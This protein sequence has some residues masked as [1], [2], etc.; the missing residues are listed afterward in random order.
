MAR[1][2]YYSAG[3]HEAAS[4]F[5][6]QKFF[7]LNNQQRRQAK[8]NRLATPEPVQPVEGILREQSQ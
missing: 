2:V 4:K 3:N 5:L 8:C 1:S 7:R 6:G